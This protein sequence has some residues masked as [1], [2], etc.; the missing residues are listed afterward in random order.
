MEARI[1]VRSTLDELL[2]E[3]GCYTPLEL[4]LAEGRLL[5]GD[6]ER[7]RN[8]EIAL[9]EES[10]F[11]D[12]NQVEEILRLAEEYCAELG[13]V[14]E[15]I[16][17]TGWGDDRR[18]EIRFSRHQEV[19]RRFRSRYRK[20]PNGHPQLDLFLDATGT[21][22]VNGIAAALGEQNFAEARRL[23]EHLYQAEPGHCHLGALERLVEAGEHLDQVPSDPIATLYKLRDE[24]TPLARELLGGESR[25]FLTPQWRKLAETL[26]NRGF[27]PNR[28]E[29]HGSYAAEQ[30]EDWPVVLSSVEQEREWHL[31]PALLRRH[32]RA[33]GRLHRVSEALADWFLL[34][35]D[36][37]DAAPNIG[38][39]AE[40]HLRVLWQR[41]SELEPELTV[42]EFPSWLL[43][44]K[45]G[46]TH[47]SPRPEMTISDSLPSSYPVTLA[48]AEQGS[49]GGPDTDSVELRRQLKNSSPT[50]F[51]HY[52]KRRSG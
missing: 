47:R 23:L 52:M 50:L 29:E 3:Q 32:A 41:F 48:L 5:Y 22:L 1:E 44:E 25:H 15:R 4:L 2:L 13:L 42:S 28:P 27:D 36:H 10:L 40:P 35:W 43:I 9:L 24:L 14:P 46:L 30:A 51:E 37:P 12:P 11:G 20:P 21:T 31:Q 45:P 16:S 34:C 49:K 7:W 8:G 38:Q 18:A 17:Y 6:Y 19:D 33:C 39:D 26:G